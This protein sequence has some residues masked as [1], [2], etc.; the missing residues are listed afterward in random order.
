MTSVERAPSPAKSRKC[1]I[2]FLGHEFRSV[3]KSVAVMLILLFTTAC[4]YHT[5]GHAVTLPQMSRPS[6][7]PHS[8]TG[9]RRTKSS[10]A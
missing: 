2:R 5:A 3:G 9:H 4:G 1:N 7:F 8:S 10:S 6:P